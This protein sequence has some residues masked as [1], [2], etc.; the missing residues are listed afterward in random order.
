M[1]AIVLIGLSNLYG[2]LSSVIDGEG[3]K[4]LEVDFAI[5]PADP[6]NRVRGPIAILFHLNCR[7]EDYE[8]DLF[9]IAKHEIHLS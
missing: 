5:V 1:I 2:S 3:P 9:S 7:M 6:N 8:Q 4:V